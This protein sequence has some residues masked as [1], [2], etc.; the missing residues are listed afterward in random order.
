LIYE[1]ITSP[2]SILL[3]SVYCVLPS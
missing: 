2:G 3:I 1:Y